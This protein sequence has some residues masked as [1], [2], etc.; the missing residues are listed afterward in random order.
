MAL[1]IFA[2][3]RVE[4]A[5]IVTHVRSS[6]LMH[7]AVGDLERTDRHP[8]GSLSRWLPADFTS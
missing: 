8:A 6:W 7:A 3:Q 4:L 2:A 1:A 5:A